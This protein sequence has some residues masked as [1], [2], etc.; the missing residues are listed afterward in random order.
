MNE[1]RKDLLRENSVKLVELIKIRTGELLTHL[2]TAGVIT[3]KDKDDIMVKITMFISVSKQN[4][5]KVSILYS[6]NIH[7]TGR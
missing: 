3:L 2:V 5:I 4:E 1:D 6:S 7:L